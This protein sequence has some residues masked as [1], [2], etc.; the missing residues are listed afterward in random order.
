MKIM[1]DQKPF[2]FMIVP[3]DLTYNVLIIYYTN[4]KSKIKKRNLCFDNI[5]KEN[6]YLNLFETGTNYKNFIKI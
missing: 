3:N 5:K 4:Q 6:E 1:K 2:T